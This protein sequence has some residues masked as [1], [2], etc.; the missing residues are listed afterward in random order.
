MARTDKYGHTADGKQPS[1]RATEYGYA[2]END[3]IHPTDKAR[4]IVR[5]E[6]SGAYAIEQK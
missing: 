6:S 2:K 5:Q 1:D 3:V 4:Y